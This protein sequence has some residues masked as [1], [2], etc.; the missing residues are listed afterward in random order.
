MNTE[1]ISKRDHFHTAA[2]FQQYHNKEMMD[3]YGVYASR[4]RLGTI[5]GL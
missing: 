2:E 1:M 3:L 4:A 5:M